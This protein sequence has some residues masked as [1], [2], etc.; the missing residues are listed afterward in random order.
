MHAM[1]DVIDMREFGGLR[2]VLPVTHVA[3]LAGALALAGIPVFSGFW[4]KDAVLESALEAG[5]SARF[6]T[7]YLVL[8]GVAL[9][10][11]LMTAFYTFRA[12]F[13]TFWGELRMPE[14]AH[15]HEPWVMA[16]PLIILA[17]G[18][19]AVG[20]VAEPFTHW[21]SGFL[22]KAP[23]VAA[24]STGKSAEHDWNWPLMAA[25]AAVG[26][27]GF[28]IAWY[29]YV[30]K[31]GTADRLAQ[32]APTLYDLS[33]NK[34]YVDDLYNVL[35]VQPA[36]LLAG[37]CRLVESIVDDLVRLV[38]VAPRY[39]A[40]LIRPIQNGLVQFYALAMVLGV[41]LFVVLV[42]FGK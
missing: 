3:F 21:F 1:H 34:L 20:I 7:V 14:G 26:L 16:L 19:L 18:A 30:R 22:T 39:F 9:V 12:Y 17:I 23:V 4:S 8:F 5:H 36:N 40:E 31:P 42:M 11:A 13:R 41:A 33:L 29:V 25:S 24:A 27:I 38:A 2:K 32:A 6:G 35:F 37:I 28:A 15:P 10:T